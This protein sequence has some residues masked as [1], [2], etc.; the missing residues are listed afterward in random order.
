MNLD[1]AERLSI[2]LKYVLHEVMSGWFK[3]YFNSHHLLKDI[4][5]HLHFR[6]LEPLQLAPSVGKE[7][8]R[9]PGTFY[10]LSIFNFINNSRLIQLITILN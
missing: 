8:V 5:S 1:A 6:S 4:P 10:R 9:T 7:Q 2:L 3:W